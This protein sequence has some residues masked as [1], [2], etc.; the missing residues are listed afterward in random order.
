MECLNEAVRGKA[1]SFPITPSET[2][3][4]IVAMLGKIDEI[5]E[6]TPIIDQPQRFG[7]KAFS[8]F[9]SKLQQSVG[10]LLQSALP[11]RCHRGIDEISVYLI[12]SVGNST[13]IDYGTGHELSFVMF[14]YCLFRIGALDSQNSDDKYAHD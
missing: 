3:T 12:E 8:T 4:A 2:V 1:L 14:L 9:Y 11:E 13:R 10:P 7:N 5:I 6:L